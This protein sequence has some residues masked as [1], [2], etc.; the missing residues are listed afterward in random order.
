MHPGVWGVRS[1]YL[2]LSLTNFY[3]IQKMKG[4]EK[5]RGLSP[6]LK[7]WFSGFGRD[8]P[9]QLCQLQKTTQMTPRN[10]SIASDPGSQLLTRYAFPRRRA[11]PL[12]SSGARGE[13]PSP[14]QVVGFLGEQSPGAR[15]YMMPVRS[16]VIFSNS[17]HFS[18]SFEQ[19]LHLLYFVPLLVCRPVSSY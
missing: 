19:Q 4:F 9:M 1:F 10:G 3:A 18:S 14:L 2:R 11:F 5:Y 6:A 16:D 13:S 12:W 7:L 17:Q 15:G 8:R